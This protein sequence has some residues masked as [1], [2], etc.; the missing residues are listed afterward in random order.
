MVPASRQL[1]PRAHWPHVRRMAGTPAATF[2]AVA[3]FTVTS[4]P[5]QGPPLPF[6]VAPPRLPVP[7][8]N[9]LQQ[10][11]LPVELPAAGLLPHTAPKGSVA[12]SASI[13]RGSRWHQWRSL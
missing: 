8:P 9:L 11:S 6:S 12:E 1:R 10:A 13:Y 7:A 2:T 3:P 4:S 5:G